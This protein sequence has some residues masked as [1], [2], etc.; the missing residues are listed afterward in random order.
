VLPDGYVLPPGS[1]IALYIPSR[2]R[3]RRWRPGEL[4]RSKGMR[5]PG[6]RVRLRRDSRGHV[7]VEDPEVLDPLT[8]REDSRT[9]EW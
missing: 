3:S 2:P 8:K 6:E 7:S 4:G 5:D 1:K 9:S